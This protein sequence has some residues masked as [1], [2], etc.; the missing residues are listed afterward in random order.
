MDKKLFLFDLDGTLSDSSEGIT[1][2]VSYALESFGIK[3]ADRKELCC[4]IGPPLPESFRKFYGFNEEEAARA[5]EIYR[6][7]YN[8]TGKFEN[9][10]YPGIRE[11][12]VHMKGRGIPAMVATSKPVVTATE[13]LEHFGFLPYF[14]KIAGSVPEE[15]R[16]KKTEVLSWLL[17]QIDL[18]KDQIVMIGDH[19]DDIHGARDNG[20]DCIGVLYGFGN[21]DQINA[22]A[23]AFTAET[24]EELEALILGRGN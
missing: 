10:P 8:V 3:V 16:Y 20:I 23:P 19:P 17:S 11:L 14:E 15:G 24:V 4:F 13:I 5:T 18:P 1:K 2:A 6:S 9:T 22:A 12:L 21:K 7:Y